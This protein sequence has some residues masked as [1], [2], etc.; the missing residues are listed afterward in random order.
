[1]HDGQPINKTQLILYAANN[2]SANKFE[3]SNHEETDDEE[4]YLS[5]ID[6]KIDNDILIGATANGETVSIPLE[7]IDPT[8]VSNIRNYLV[9]Y[10]LNIDKVVDQN[11]VKVRSYQIIPNKFKPNEQIIKYKGQTMS[12]PENLK[13]AFIEE[14]NKF[15]MRRTKSLQ[16]IFEKLK[17]KHATD[18]HRQQ[19]S[20][21]KSATASAV[22]SSIGS[23]K[24][25]LSNIPI[26]STPVLNTKKSVQTT[27]DNIYRQKKRLHFNDQNGKGSDKKFKWEKI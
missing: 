22:N 26:T 24:N 19:H 12:I 8:V 17:R 20:L 23:K 15:S 25:T 5:L 7:K 11:D 10:H 13:D 27:V 14:M 2:D 16:E 21:Y 4:I 6:T 3:K 9:N 18:V 1:M